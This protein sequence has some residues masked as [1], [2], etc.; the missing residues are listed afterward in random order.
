MGKIFPVREIRVLVLAFMGF[1]EDK[2]Q[3][4]ASALIFNTLLSI[5]PVA[6]I[7]FGIAQSFDFKERPEI[8]IRHAL[9]GH[10]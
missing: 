10:G 4:R 5:I 1:M 2:V 9:A 8:E 3:F 6:A 7:A